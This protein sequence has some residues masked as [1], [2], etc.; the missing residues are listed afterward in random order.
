MFAYFVEFLQEDNNLKISFENLKGLKKSAS[1]LLDSEVQSQNLRFGW[2][3][4]VDAHSNF[5]FGLIKETMKD[6]M[7]LFLILIGSIFIFVGQIQESIILFLAIIPLVFMDAFLHWRTQASTKTLLGQ[8]VSEV[9][10]IRHGKQSHINT[11]SLVP[12]DLIVVSPEQPFVPVDGVWEDTDRIQVDESM[13]TGESH[14]ILKEKLE[15]DPFEMSEKGEVFINARSF[16]YAGTRLLTGNG[17]LRALFIGKNTFYG[18]IVQSVANLT[19][20]KTPLQISI[21]KL[22]QSLIYIS[23]IFCILLAAVRLFQGYG[24][25]DAI[26]SAGT[27]AIAAFPEE[28]PVVFTFFLGVGVYRLA[29]R[30]ALVRRAVSVENIGRITQICTDKT[31]TITFGLLTLTHI[32]H[33]SD[34]TKED[35]LIS[36]L[37]ASDPS[38]TDPVD[39][40]IKEYSKDLVAD[41]LIREFIV[42]FTEDRKRQVAFVVK[43]EKS[44]CYIKGSPEIIL[45]RSNISKADNDKCEMLINKW[46]SEGLKV[47]ASAWREISTDELNNR[48]EPNSGFHFCGLMAFEDPPRPEVQNAMIYCQRNNIH[49]LMITGDHSKTAL[50][51]AKQVG[52]GGISPKVISAEENQEKFEEAWLNDNPLFLRNIDIVARCNPLQKF[53]IVN[54]LRHSGEVVAVTGDGVNDV[55]ALKAADIGIAMGVRGTRSAKEVASI[56]LADD[57]FS[58]IVN[59]IMEGRQLFLNLK[60]SFEYLLYFHIPFVLSAALIPLMGYQLIYLPV[61]VV[62][63]ELIIHPTA[64]FAFQQVSSTDSENIANRESFFYSK[65]EKTRFFLI[66]LTFSIALMLIYILTLASNSNTGLARAKIIAL[67]SLWSAGLVFKLTKGKNLFAKA[68]I[69][70]PIALA[71]ILIQVPVLS[72]SLYLSPL[73]AL[74]WLQLVLVV[75]IFLFLSN[76]HQRFQRTKSLSIKN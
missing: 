58:T 38:A 50:A 5:W 6:P 67:L 39:K 59:A 45:E 44:I 30:H 23:F 20:D 49:V 34:S 71:L 36:A 74:D 9:I 47:L 40:A 17:L 54:A 73:R 72:K 29:K 11:L 3:E 22:V 61:H 10:V 14:P 12:G 46:A 52:L 75:I 68:M 19:H 41:Q 60:M 66:G 37:A 13:L 53:R 63:L 1:G 15:F 33:T 26:L 70:S 55:P 7:I 27:L 43:N 21:S 62:W 18:E 32:E 31:G 4:I 69:A 16:G 35:V 25:L 65:G 8:L 76:I 51:I 2:N 42:P 56:V 24:W 28:F 64:L 48:I 57:N